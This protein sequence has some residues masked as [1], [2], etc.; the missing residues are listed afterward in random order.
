MSASYIYR[1]HQVNKSNKDLTDKMGNVATS[2]IRKEKDL[3]VTL[4]VNLK[5]SEYFG[6]AALKANRILGLIRQYIVGLIPENR[7]HAE[8]RCSYIRENSE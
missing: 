2:T 6:I 8:G 4:S 1:W 3:E 5:V 7:I